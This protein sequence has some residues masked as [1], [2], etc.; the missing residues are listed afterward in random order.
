MSETYSQVMGVR[1]YL[2]YSCNFSL[3]LRSLKKKKKQPKELG[4]YFREEREKGLWMFGYADNRLCHR[5][6]LN[7]VS[8]EIIP[9]K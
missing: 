3:S 8:E 9:R 4:L 7:N 6:Y 2:Y 1:N 5:W